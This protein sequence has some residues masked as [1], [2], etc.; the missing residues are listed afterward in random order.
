MKTVY[1]ETSIPSYLTARASSDV[2]AI[3]WQQVTKQWWNEE[4]TKYTL[5]ISELVIA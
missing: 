5:F 3:T 4:R 1:I 2:K